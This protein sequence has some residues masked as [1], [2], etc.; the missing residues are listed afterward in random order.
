LQLEYLVVRY[1]KPTTLY[2]WD[3][4]IPIRDAWMEWATPRG[5]KV[6]DPR[7]VKEIEHIQAARDRE[8]RSKLDLPKDAEITDEMRTQHAP[9]PG[10]IR[11][12]FNEFMD[13][14][15]NGEFVGVTNYYAVQA[16]NKYASQ[17]SAAN[18]E[19][20]APSAPSSEDVTHVTLARC[21]WMVVKNAD[22]WLKDRR[23]ANWRPRIFNKFKHGAQ[24]SL[25]VCLNQS[26]NEGL[27]DSSSKP[28]TVIF[29]DHK[30]P[31]VLDD[32]SETVDEKLYQR[33]VELVRELP[34][35]DRKL[36]CWSNGRDP[37][38]LEPAQ[39]LKDSQIAKKLRID[40]KTV[41]ERRSRIKSELKEE[42]RDRSDELRLKRTDES[43]QRT[44]ERKHDRQVDEAR[45]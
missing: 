3:R 11:E 45:T 34:D 27:K 4:L 15:R 1:T 43:E 5:I 33:Y 25:H 40:V 20:S 2:E 39:V 14:N 29:D 23:A 32:I 21:A 41:E 37:E 36:W 18:E 12:F 31:A 35:K 17:R 7:H 16:V 19:H 9:L 24:K 38:T 6:Q 26:Q 8:V 28:N 22:E 44:Q 30:E 10:P 13:V 42:L